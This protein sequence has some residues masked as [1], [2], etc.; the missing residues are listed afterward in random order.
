MGLVESET[1][2]RRLSTGGRDAMS[3]TPAI[4]R[5][6]RRGDDA[7]SG[8]LSSRILEQ[9]PGARTAMRPG[10]IIGPVESPVVADDTRSI[11]R[12]TVL[13]DAVFV[14]GPADSWSRDASAKI[15]AS[16]LDEPNHDAI[17]LYNLLEIRSGRLRGVAGPIAQYWPLTGPGDT[18]A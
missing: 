17:V 7:T 12:L 4:T 14:R 9:S 5:Q 15:D 1:L 6:H 16:W 2:R 11:H 10:T 8:L 13:N 3:D 18:D